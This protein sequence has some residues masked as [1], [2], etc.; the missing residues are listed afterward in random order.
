MKKTIL[1]YILLIA[2]LSCKNVSEKKETKTS[3]S[4]KAIEFYDLLRELIPNESQKEA[5]VNWDL[6]TEMIEWSFPSPTFDGVIYS[7]SAET[8]VSLN[9]SKNPVNCF[10]FFNGRTI[11]GYDEIQITVNEPENYK[12]ENILVNT[13]LTSIKLLK[14][15]KEGFPYYEYE[16]RLPNKKPIWLIIMRDL[17]GQINMYE[18]NESTITIVCLFNKIEYERR[19]ED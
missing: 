13:S 16:L 9:D 8:T 1:I 3:D 15:E 5:I 10:L 11:D 2:M 12:L 17:E 19:T 7:N 18:E 6:Q 4:E 14:E